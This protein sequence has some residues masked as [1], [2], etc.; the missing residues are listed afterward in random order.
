MRVSLHGAEPWS[1]AVRVRI[2][3]AYGTEAFDQY[4]LTEFFG[5]GVGVECSR[6]E[7]IHI[8]TDHFIAEIVDPTSGEIVRD[9]EEGE[10]VLTSL[11]REAVPLI[12]FRTRDLTRLIPEPCACGL[13]FPRFARIRGRTVDTVIYRGVKIYPIQLEEAL[14][15]VPQTSGN[16]Q[17]E[18]T[19]ESG[20]DMM[21]VRAEAADWSED[22]RQSMQAEIH[23]GLGVQV[24]VELVK[25]GELR[26]AEDRTPKL[27]RI[28]DL[29]PS[30]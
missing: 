6:H 16:Y 7:G 28:I 12:R 14:L 26:L 9:G 5:P 23:A 8:F 1:E 3:Q 25:P 10:L 27:K 11:T 18:I 24:E 17:V 2:Q 21:K 20:R 29:R 13:P 15:R 19:R 4:G 30:L 22:L